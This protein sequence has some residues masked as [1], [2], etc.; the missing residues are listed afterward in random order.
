MHKIKE[1][2]VDLDEAMEKIMND[3]NT[4]RKKEVKSKFSYANTGAMIRETNKGNIE[5][6]N[7]DKY[8]K[9]L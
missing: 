5:F 4:E 2:D 8:I 3:Q 6:P 9:R 7:H 1:P